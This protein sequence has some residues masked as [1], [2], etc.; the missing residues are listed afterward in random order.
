MEASELIQRGLLRLAPGVTMRP[1][2]RSGTT[3]LTGARSGSPQNHRVWSC[4][5]QE[6]RSPSADLP[7]QYFEP[8]HRAPPSRERDGWTGQSRTPEDGV[9][10]AVTAA[11]S[12]NRWSGARDRCRCWDCQHGATERATVTRR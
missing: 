10:C 8:S 12:H 9:P 7:F 1:D 6:L 5:H 3:R 4:P 11:A 2:P